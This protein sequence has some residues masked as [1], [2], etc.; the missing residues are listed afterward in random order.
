[1]SPRRRIA[2]LGLG[3]VLM[4]DD[5][6]GPWAV[7]ELESRF[8]IPPGVSVEDLGTPGLDLHPHLADADAVIL[9]DTVRAAGRPGELRCYRRDEILCDPPAQ[10][11][12]PHDPGVKQALLA[13]EFARTGP[14]DVFLAG[15]IP[16]RAGQEI[17][18]SEEVRSALPALLDAVVGELERLGCPAERRKSPLPLELLWEQEAERV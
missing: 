4:G 12:G 16:A 6:L 17:G 1:M 5:G 9:I 13:A 18:L 11:A 8:V 2:V 10:R 7:R 15:V 3:N 14:R